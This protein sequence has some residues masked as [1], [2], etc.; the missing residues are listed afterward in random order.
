MAT[1][2]FRARRAADLERLADAVESAL[3]LELLGLA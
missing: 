1:V 2:N 3:N